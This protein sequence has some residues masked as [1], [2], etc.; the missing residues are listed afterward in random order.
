MGNVMPCGSSSSSTTNG[1]EID[2]RSVDDRG[3]I[4]SP[5][6]TSKQLFLSLTTFTILFLKG[7]RE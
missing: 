6:T 7:R 4:A 2:E 5:L 1:S 3:N